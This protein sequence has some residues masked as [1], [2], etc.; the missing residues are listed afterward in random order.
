MYSYASRVVHNWLGLASNLLHAFPFLYEMDR[1]SLTI[2]L[3]DVLSIEDPSENA[4]KG[5]CAAMVGVL[6]AAVFMAYDSRSESK[7]SIRMD[8]DGQKRD[9]WSLVKKHPL[10]TLA[11]LKYFFDGA[12]TALLHITDVE[13]RLILLILTAPAMYSGIHY[14]LTYNLR[15][16]LENGEKVAKFPSIHKKFR[17][18]LADG[19]LKE[20]GAAFYIA[21]LQTSAVVYNMISFSYSAFEQVTKFPQ[22]FLNRPDVD[23]NSFAIKVPAYANATTSLIAAYHPSRNTLVP[24]LRLMFHDAELDPECYRVAQIK[25]NNRSL[26]K[27]LWDEFCHLFFSPGT[28][29][30]IPLAYSVV[31]RIEEENYLAAAWISLC[32]PVAHFSYR[33]AAEKMCVTDIAKQIADAGK[34]LP[35]KAAK[36]ASLFLTVCEQLAFLLAG[37]VGGLILLNGDFYDSPHVSDL[38]RA[39]ETSREKL[40]WIYCAS[41]VIAVGQYPFKYN[42]RIEACMSGLPSLFAIKPTIAAE[43]T[44]E[45]DLES[46]NQFLNRANSDSS[47]ALMHSESPPLEEKQADEND[48]DETNTNKAESWCTRIRKCFS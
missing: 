24:D 44:D 11:A 19:N 15:E 41:L 20:A 30:N 39:P 27:K 4:I 12:F 46:G 36:F 32:I 5:V 21:M 3:T 10:L 13:P 38:S 35:N 14:Y 17:D 34:A 2:F 8:L 18:H 28:F 37:A 9:I 29:L 16:I 47:R 25:F 40:L 42:K 23:V 45:K 48:V 43:L 7:K 26:G 6:M 22:Y 33:A 1:I 31:S